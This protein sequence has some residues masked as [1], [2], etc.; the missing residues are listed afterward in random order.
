M[1]MKIYPFQECCKRTAIKAY[2]QGLFYFITCD[3]CEKLFSITDQLAFFIEHVII[4]Y[5]IT[6]ITANF[7]LV[8]YDGNIIFLVS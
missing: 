1:I 7:D 8:L 3:S 4:F 5:R 6:D 2:K